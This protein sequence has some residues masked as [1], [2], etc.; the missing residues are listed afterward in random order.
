MS[1][2]FIEHFN[3]S[4]LTIW[5]T[6]YVPVGIRVYYYTKKELAVISSKKY[7]ESCSSMVEFC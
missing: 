1:S 2:L 5:G 6:E 7:F 3:Y 4:S